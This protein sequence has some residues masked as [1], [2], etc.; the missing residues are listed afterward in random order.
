MQP[1]LRVLIIKSRNYNLLKYLFSK[2][3]IYSI[4][5]SPYHLEITW[6]KLSMSLLLI[7][8]SGSLLLIVWTIPCFL[9]IIF[10]SRTVIPKKKKIFIQRTKN[11]T[12]SCELQVWSFRAIPFL[13]HHKVNSIPPSSSFPRTFVS[14]ST[15]LTL[16]GH[17]ICFLQFFLQILLLLQEARLLHLTHSIQPCYFR[18]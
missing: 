12:G 9:N 15:I 3:D 17:C 6:N 16:Q 2:N 4:F 1:M 11:T 7:L 14:H 18:C 13:L 8:I 10:T 5:V